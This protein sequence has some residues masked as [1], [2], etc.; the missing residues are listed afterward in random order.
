MT[1]L[2]TRRRYGITLAALLGVVPAQVARGQTAFDAPPNLAQAWTLTPG[3]IQFNLLH[4]FWLGPPPSRKLLNSPTLSVAIGWNNAIT[5]G[6]NYA[7]SSE[8]ATS[9]PNELELFGRAAVVRQVRGSPVDLFVQGGYNTA[10]ESVDGQFLL[11]R[12]VGPL[13]A[14][15]AMGVLGEAFE[16]GLTRVTVGGGATLQLASF[17][18]ITG[19][20]VSLTD[21]RDEED[22]AWS[23]GLMV[24]VR[25]TPHTLS[26]HAS[27]VASRT[28]Q[29]MAR[30]SGRT[31]YGFEYTIPVNL[32][33]RRAG[34]SRPATPI[35]VTDRATGDTVWIDIRGMRFTQ[36]RVEV[37][38]G[39][40]VVWRNRDPLT[41][42][43][44]R[45]DEQIHSGDIEP[46]ATWSMTFT[47]SGRFSYHCTPHPFMRGEV[48]V[49]PSRSN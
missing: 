32:T 15:A 20:L 34:T 24:G 47:T 40:T 35:Q 13:R 10:S 3:V 46:G 7:T 22:V 25:G 41:H 29:G 16:E 43:V 45:E 21:R 2:H 4:R 17:I 49:R 9:R 26:L 5:T 42:T 23:A 30:G 11:A 38:Q 37:A 44:T 27:N 6:M 8:I 19:D 14:V 39:T 48:I 1:P 36:D 31:R 12:M 33:R 18:G 28:V